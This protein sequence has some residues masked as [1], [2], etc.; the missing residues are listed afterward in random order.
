[1]A[2]CREVDD[3]IDLILAHDGADRV[4]VTDVCLD[5][6]IIRTILYVMEI[7]EVSGVCELVQIDDMVVRI[8]IDEKTDHM[9]AYEAGTAGNDYAPFEIHNLFKFRRV[10]LFVVVL[11]D[12]Y[13][14]DN[15]RAFEI[16]QQRVRRVFLAQD[17][18]PGRN[19]PVDADA[20]VQDADASV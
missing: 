19:L 12:L 9:T 14:I 2:F 4:N 8:F 17:C 20:V 11:F 7:G 18:C 1:M 15:E 5:E 16:F 6:S 3:S 13:I 10:L